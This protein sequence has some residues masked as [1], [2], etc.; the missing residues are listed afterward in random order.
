VG[1]VDEL[2]LEPGG[3]FSWGLAGQA[4]CRVARSKD[5]VDDLGRLSIQI[6]RD[7][8]ILI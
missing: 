6:A 7:A 3:D 2:V 1:H 5:H 8:D 4:D